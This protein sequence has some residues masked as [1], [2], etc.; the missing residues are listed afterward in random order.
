MISRL[1]QEVFRMTKIVLSDGVSTHD[2]SVCGGDV[3]GTVL[4]GT[5]AFVKIAGTLIMVEDGTLE[6]PSHNNPPCTPPNFSTHSFTSDTFVQSF[7]K[8]EGKKVLLVGDSFSGDNTF[9]SGE[10]GNTFVEIS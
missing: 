6:V 1:V 10:G 9:I 5:N 2:G 4:V 8:I 7:T 3:L